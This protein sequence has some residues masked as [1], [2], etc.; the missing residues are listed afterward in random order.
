MVELMSRYSVQVELDS[1][2]RDVA[3]LGSIIE[4][5]CCYSFEMTKV[6]P[7]GNIIHTKM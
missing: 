5:S 7:T 1:Y 4:R 3:M 6:A 2:T